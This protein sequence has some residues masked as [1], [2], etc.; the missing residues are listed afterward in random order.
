MNIL[1]SFVFISFCLV[2][3]PSV[4][5]RCS[6]RSR[7]RRSKGDMASR[8]GGPCGS[9]PPCDWLCG[10][11]RRRSETGWDCALCSMAP[12]RMETKPVITCLKS[13]LVVYSFVFWV[14]LAGL[15]THS[16]VR[17]LRACLGVYYKYICVKSRGRASAKQVRVVSDLW[18]ILYSFK[19]TFSVLVV[20]FKD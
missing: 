8:V 16:C 5:Q 6:S 3:L 7:D 14:S 1:V 10:P 15:Y 20:W 17:C 18:F 19:D 4:L 11:E 9:V 13:L 12:R 2:H